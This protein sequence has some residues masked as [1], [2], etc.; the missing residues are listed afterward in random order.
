[1]ARY[2]DVSDARVVPMASWGSERIMPIGSEQ[3]TP[4]P[5]HLDIAPS[6]AV[7]ECD[8]V[9]GALERGWQA[10]ARR[11]PSSHAPLPNT[12]ALR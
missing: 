6:F 10:I 4:A 9:R 1:V 3:I 2:L 11:L 5:M 8:G 7:T 12:E